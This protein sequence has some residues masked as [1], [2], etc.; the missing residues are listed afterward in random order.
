MMNSGIAHFEE[1]EN[2]RGMVC[3][4]EAEDDYRDSTF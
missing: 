3:F 1:A 4:E 2:E